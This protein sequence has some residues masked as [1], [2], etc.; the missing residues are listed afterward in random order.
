MTLL[1]IIIPTF[2]VS[3]KI[4]ACFSSLDDLHGQVSSLEVIFIDDHSTDDTFTMVEQFSRSRNWVSQRRLDANCGSPSEPRNIGLTLASGE[5]VFF[6]DPDDEILPAGV[7]KEITIAQSTGADCVRSPLI[8]FDGKES[9]VMNRIEDWEHLETRH[10]QISAIV[11]NHSTT[12]CALYR[13]SFLIDNAILWPKELRLAE[14]AIF[15]Y[16]VLSKGH[17]EYSDE[18]D[19][20]YNMVVESSGASS[21]Q[22]YN[23]RELRNHVQAWSKSV[24][25]LSVIGIDYMKLRGQVALQTAFQNMIRFNR[26]G[27]DHEDLNLLREFLRK[28]RKFVSKYTYGK[29]FAELCK[30]ILDGDF[31]AFNEKIKLRLLIAGYDLRFIVPAVPY[32]SD[33]FDIR[34]DEWTGHEIHDEEKSRRLVGWAD[35]IHC[36]WMLG[37][38]VWYAKNKSSHQTLQV[39]IHRFETTRDYGHALKDLGV[40]R[41]I[42]IAPGMFEEV[43]RVFGFDRGILRY[44]PNY[45]ETDAY[46]RSDNPTK[47]FNLCMV[48][49]IPIRKGYRRALELLNSLR[50]IDTRYTLTVYG[51]APHELGWVIN[52]PIER[53]YFA[54]CDK[55]VRENGLENSVKFLGWVNTKEALEDKGFVLSL[56]DAEG[57]HVAAAEGFASGN[58]TLLRPWAGAEYMYPN[59][60]IFAGIHEMR[61]YVLECRDYAE[62]KA[63]AVAGEKFVRTRYDMSVFVEQFDQF[64][65]V[66]FSVS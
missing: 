38:C 54:K 50:Q 55:F 9:R 6:L 47:V 1:S 42:T 5:F 33:F 49:S 20:K 37:N 2:N 15:L 21:T 36:E 56:S 44:A 28:H 53:D 46:R 41:V 27:L 16:T 32:L 59:E 7:V 58:I 43:Q 66:P 64:L 29:R 51:K 63:R 3:S 45:I 65:P 57:S 22:Q 18:P 10:E 23:G 14:D 12:V 40:D 31:N 30:L 62:F 8:R 25:I 60:Y 17:V 24:D 52:D 34:I 48:G 39:R 26:G 19:F 13:R 35:V 4:G 11:K 61:D